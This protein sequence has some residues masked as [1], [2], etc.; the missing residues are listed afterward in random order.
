MHNH[1]RNVTVICMHNLACGSVD[2]SIDTFIAYSYLEYKQAL[3]RDD[4]TY[5]W[6]NLPIQM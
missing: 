5:T 4:V 6:S 2:N 1:E 3:N